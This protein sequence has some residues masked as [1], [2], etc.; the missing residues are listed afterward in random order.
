[1]PDEAQEWPE[2]SEWLIGD[3]LY[4][5]EK[6]RRRDAV[7]ETGEWKPVWMVMEALASQHGDDNV[8]L[9]VWF[10]N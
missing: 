2:G 3:A 5:S 6:L 10:G 4:R 7:P 8:R 9:V 1:M